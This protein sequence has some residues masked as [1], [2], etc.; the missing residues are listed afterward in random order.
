M[1]N[2]PLLAAAV[3]SAAVLRVRKKTMVVDPL[4]P[5]VVPPL[6]VAVNYISNEFRLLF[7]S[8]SDIEVE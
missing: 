3:L 4:E 5:S 6:K 8:V 2:A 1:F 7:P